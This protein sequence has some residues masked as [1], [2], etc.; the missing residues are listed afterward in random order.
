[1]AAGKKYIQLADGDNHNEFAFWENP[2]KD[3][4]HCLW[5]FHDLYDHSY[6]KEYVC[7]QSLIIPI[8]HDPR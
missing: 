4:Y 1:M 2:M 7:C 6:G 3:D 8:R 5:M